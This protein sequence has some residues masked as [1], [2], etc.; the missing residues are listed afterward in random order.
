MTKPRIRTLD[1]EECEQILSRN[2]VGRLA[3][4]W[5][6]HVDIEP[7]HYVFAGQW[8][9]GRTSRG[10]KLVV[11]GEQWWPVAFE[12]DEVEGLFQWRSVVVHGGFYGIAEGGPEW[13]EAAR[14]QGLELLRT[15]L[16]ETLTPDDPA[17]HRTVL[18]RIALQELSGR[19][20]TP[21]VPAE[22]PCA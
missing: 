17:P 12:V 20:A 2:H 13:Q 11:T 5:K 8:L 10:T 6:N 15:L 4:A 16:P 22:T 19:E 7:L 9:Y 3:Y 21:G 14:N 1:R 18:F